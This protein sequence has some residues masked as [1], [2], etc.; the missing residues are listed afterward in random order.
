MWKFGSLL[1]VLVCVACGGEEGVE[2]EPSIIGRWLIEN[3]STG[4]GL[5]LTE[6]GTYT[7]SNMKVLTDARAEVELH[8]GTYQVTAKELTLYQTESSCR[9]EVRREEV[10]A[11]KLLGDTLALHLPEKT[12][13]LKRSSALRDYPEYVLTFGCFYMDGFVAGPLTTLP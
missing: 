6:K 8:G 7:L 11:Y 2:E 9:D 12:L 5:T 3:A 13:N 10:L 1:A 4:S